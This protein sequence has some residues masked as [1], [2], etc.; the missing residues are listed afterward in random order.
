[1]IPISR[2]KETDAPLCPV[3]MNQSVEIDCSSVFSD[4][5]ELN[6]KIVKSIRSPMLDT[7]SEIYTCFTYVLYLFEIH[8]ANHTYSHDFTNVRQLQY[9]ASQGSLRPLIRFKP[10]SK[11]TIMVSI[12]VFRWVNAIIGFGPVRRK[13]FPSEAEPSCGFF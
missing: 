5:T 8:L 3:G 4:C 13:L 6:D 9:F 11:P 12:I 2:C 7:A 10:R 1:M